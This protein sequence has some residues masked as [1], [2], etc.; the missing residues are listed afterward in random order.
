MKTRKILFIF[1]ALTL[2]R[3][4]GL[5]EYP[6]LLST[7]QEITSICK[8]RFEKKQE[9]SRE[10]GKLH[11]K[12]L[13]YFDKDH[14]TLW[15]NNKIIRPENSHAIKGFCLENITFRNATFSWVVP[16]SLIP[17]KF[18]LNPGQTYDLNEHKI[19]DGTN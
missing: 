4:E 16:P 17:K 19:I 12:A 15:I 6:S 9:C 3:G 13:V 5:C 2:F 1:N 8:N 10:F 7:E 11:L 18:T 14:W